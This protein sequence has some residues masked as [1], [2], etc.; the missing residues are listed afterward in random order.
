MKKS[1]SFLEAVVRNCSIRKIA[2]TILPKFTCN[3][4]IKETPTQVYFCKF[5]KCF[6]KPILQN[7]CKWLLLDF[8]Q[9]YLPHSIIH[10]GEQ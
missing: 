6:K 10:Q 7:T 9:F 4:T 5:S 1:L 3:L 2:D 8:E